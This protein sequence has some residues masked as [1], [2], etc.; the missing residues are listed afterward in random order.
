MTD[1]GLGNA[2]ATTTDEGQQATTEDAAAAEEKTAQELR[3]ARAA[4]RELRAK[5]AERGEADETSKSEIQK[6][7]DRIAQAEGR[8]Q[9]AELRALRVEIAHEKG[10]PAGMARRLQGST[11]EEIEEDADDLTKTM[12][13]PP[14]RRSQ[15]TD[16]G[17]H[18]N[19]QAVTK[20]PNDWLR[21]KIEGKK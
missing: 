20:S 1:L 5:L 15:S 16:A 17:Q 9:E 6:A 7:A 11:R 4:V 13:Q 2:S 18:A 19:G 10:L 3:K 8:A 12:P 21:E 14:Q